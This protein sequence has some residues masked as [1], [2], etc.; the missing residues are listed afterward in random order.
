MLQLSTETMAPGSYI[1]VEDKEPK[2]YFYI[3]REGSVQGIRRYSKQSRT[4]DAGSV[5][6]VVPCMT[7]RSQ[8]ESVIAKSQ[9]TLVKVLRSQYEEFIKGNPT[10]A[11][12]IVQMLSRDLRSFNEAYDK[13]TGGLSRM[14]D[15]T[16]KLYETARYYEEK[17][18]TDVA[19]FAY[20]QY[21]KEA[22]DGMYAGECRRAYEKI[23]SKSHAVYLEPA[24]ETNRFYPKGTMVFAEGQTGSEMFIIGSGAVCI[25]KVSGGEEQAIV[26]FKKGDQLGEMALLENEF[27]SANAIATEDSNLIVLNRKNFDLMVTTQPQY[28]LKLTAT[29]ANRYWYSYR[30]Y[31]NACL[32]DS[33]ERLVDMLAIQ[34]EMKKEGNLRPTNYETGLKVQDMM[35]LCNLEGAGPDEVLYLLQGTQDVAVNGG[36]VVIKDVESLLKQAE[37]Y[38]KKRDKQTV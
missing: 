35:V 34:V 1:F 18:M 12:K 21:M 33:R 16:V 15:R 38:R 36:K 30:R 13:K 10:I 27:R 5:I 24:E 14:K 19:A 2:D 8:T 22:P 23:Q 29:L 4:Y 28:I 25:S 32:S 37:F 6:G 11:M 26:Y 20:Y 7:G 17:E 9:V 31:G 3:I